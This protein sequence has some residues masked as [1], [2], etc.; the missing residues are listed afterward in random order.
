[1]AGLLTSFSG[2]SLSEHTEET[3][4]LTTLSAMDISDDACGVSAP[5][6]PL[7][8]EPDCP[9]KHTHPEGMYKHEGKPPHKYD[10]ILGDSNPPPDVWESLAKMNDG[11]ATVEDDLAIAC[12]LKYHVPGTDWRF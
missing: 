9:I 11:S 3:R 8:T 12:F 4:L 6:M 7:C 1:M 2:L 5:S 10:F